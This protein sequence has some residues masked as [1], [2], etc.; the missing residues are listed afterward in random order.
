MRKSLY[1][2]PVL[3]LGLFG[4]S[5]LMAQSRTPAENHS[6]PQW[7]TIQDHH[8]DEI[9]MLNSDPN[10]EYILLDDHDK[11][12]DIPS[13]AGYNSGSGTCGFCGSD[14][15]DEDIFQG[16]SNRMMWDGNF[17]VY[18]IP[19][20]DGFFIRG[21]QFLLRADLFGMDGRLIRTLAPTDAEISA[22]DLA[23][24]VYILRMDSGADLITRRLVIQ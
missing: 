18:P 17:E 3:C 4:G 9:D 23:P 5:L 24:G 13:K 8:V 15:T 22:T 21:G 10:E 1:T 14:D 12:L 19:A 16:G 11:P 6:K 2:L 7:E 20:K